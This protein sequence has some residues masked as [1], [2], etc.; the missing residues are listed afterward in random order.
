MWPALSRSVGRC[1]FLGQVTIGFRSGHARRCVRALSRDDSRR[2]WLTALMWLSPFPT[3]SVQAS[4]L[5]M[6]FRVRVPTGFHRLLA[7]LRGLG[8]GCVSPS[9][10]F[11]FLRPLSL[12]S[13][14]YL[15]PN[16]LGSRWMR[17]RSSKR[18]HI[19]LFGSGRLGGSGG[20]GYRGPVDMAGGLSCVV[21]GRCP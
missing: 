20:R 5:V 9:V 2:G 17:Y 13:A 21:W 14:D 16:A 4:S 15:C 12:L 1:W 7:S 11:L 6:D 19:D 8:L 18:G 3:L 10:C